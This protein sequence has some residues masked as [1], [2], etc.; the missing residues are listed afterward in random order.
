MRIGNQDFAIKVTLSNLLMHAHNNGIPFQ[1]TFNLLGKLTAVDFIRLAVLGEKTGKLTEEDVMA[2]I[3]ENPTAFT[4]LVTEVSN[5]LS[6][7]VDKKKT[8]TV[9]KKVAKR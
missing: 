7:S 9:T 3:D 6:A 8:E 2:E 5:Q 4:E 1:D